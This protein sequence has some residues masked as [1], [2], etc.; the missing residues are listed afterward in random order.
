MAELRKDEKLGGNCEKEEEEKLIESSAVLDFDVLCSTVAMQSQGKWRLFE[1]EEDEQSGGCGGGVG[2]GGG[3]VLRMWEGEILDCFDDHSI[4]IQSFC[5]PCYRFGKNMKRAGQG[6]CFIQGTVY[7]ILAVSVFLNSVAFIITRKSCFLYLA[8]AVTVSLGTY[9]GFFRT[10]IRNK[11]NI[12]VCIY[13]VF[14]FHISALP[15][16]CLV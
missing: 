4:A 13:S 15:Y 16:S 6:S 14:H 9:L 12:M 5:C 7:L 3:G 2:G 1:N 10:Q 8:V 11:F